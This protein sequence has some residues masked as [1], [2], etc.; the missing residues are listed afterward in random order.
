MYLSE[1]LKRLITQNSYPN[2]VSWF[3]SFINTQVWE[4]S[5]NVTVC[6]KTVLGQSFAQ[7]C[8][9]V[10]GTKAR[11]ALVLQMSEP[12]CWCWK[13]EEKEKAEWDLHMYVCLC[14]FVFKTKLKNHSFVSN[15]VSTIVM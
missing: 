5:R 7:P 9:D 10:N 11:E 12:Y 13:E 15:Q 3:I 14:Y 4:I 1:D 8:C 2:L 6:Y